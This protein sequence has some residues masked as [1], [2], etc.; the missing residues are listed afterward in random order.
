MDQRSE[1]NK[2]RAHN[3]QQTKNTEKQ[4]TGAQER[5]R[6]GRKR[7]AKEI[8]Q[9]IRRS[10]KNEKARRRQQQDFLQQKKLV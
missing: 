8:R 3:P 9:A 1:E 2:L 5:R 4:S 6:E 10:L 7:E